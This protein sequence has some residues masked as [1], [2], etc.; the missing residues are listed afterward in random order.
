MIEGKKI[1]KLIKFADEPEFEGE[2][3]QLKVAEKSVDNEKEDFKEAFKHRRKTEVEKLDDAL[4]KILDTSND[5]VTETQKERYNNTEKTMNYNSSENK[6]DRIYNNNNNNNNNNKSLP[7]T[8]E[9]SIEEEE[10]EKEDKKEMVIEKS[11]S[12][13][14]MIGRKNTGKRHILQR[15]LEVKYIV[16]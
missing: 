15:L 11:F 14:L 5:S 4:L 8:V 3:K 10:N 13:L 6:N 1:R 7:I 9:S 16:Y 12:K 2:P